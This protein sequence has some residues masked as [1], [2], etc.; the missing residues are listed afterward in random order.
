MSGVEILSTTEVVAES[1][2]NVELACLLWLVTIIVCGIFG[3]F[4]ED[5]DKVGAV[6]LG[7][8][9]GAMCGIFVFVA[10]G[11]GTTEVV[12]YETHYKVTVSDEVSMNEFLDKYKI[13][14]QEGEIYTVKERK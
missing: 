6:M 1:T 14:D 12:A 9:V 7:C 8:V 5:K 13:I 2:S 4:L 11:V 3:Y 10:V